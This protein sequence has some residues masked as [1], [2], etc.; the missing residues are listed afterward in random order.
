MNGKSVGLN[1]ELP[2]EQYANPYID[3]DKLINFNYFFV[4]R[5]CW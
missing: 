2:F 3:Q 5:S 4:G 1:I